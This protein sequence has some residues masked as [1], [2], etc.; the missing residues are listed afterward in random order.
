MPAL[1]VTYRERNL[2]FIILRRESFERN[3]RGYKVKEGSIVIINFILSLS[4]HFSV[5]EKPALEGGAREDRNQR[6]Y[7]CWRVEEA[8]EQAKET[9][10]GCAP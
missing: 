6:Q 4:V 7:Y 8:P 10:D 3:S 1:R 9:G 5:P 2:K